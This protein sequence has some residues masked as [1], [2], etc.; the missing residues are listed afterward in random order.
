MT[1]DRN[2]RND[3][4]LKVA[5]RSGPIIRGLLLGAGFIF[6]GLGIVGAVLPL[7]PTTPFILLAAACFARSSKRFHRWLLGNRTFGPLIERWERE[8]TISRRAK[9]ATLV[10]LAVTLSVSGLLATQTMWHRLILA[11]TGVIVATIVLLIPSQRSK[12]Q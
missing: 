6:L 9:L 4:P 2:E 12:P 11:A 1:G 7:L 3:T 8:R 10:T 5:Q